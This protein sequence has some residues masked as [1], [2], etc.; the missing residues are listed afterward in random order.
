[1]NGPRRHFF[2]LHELL[3]MAALAA[4]GGVSSTMMSNIRAAV[5]A[6]VGLPGGM[7][8]TAGVHVVWLIIAVGLVR[9]PGAATVT[10][11]L[12]GT[13]ELLSGNLHGLLVILYAVLAGVGVDLVWLLLGRRH[14]PVTYMLAGGVGTASN[15]LVLPFLASLPYDEGGLIAG[16]TLLTAVAFLSGVLLAGLLGWSLLH[17]LRAAGVAGAQPP[18]PPIRPSPRT[19]AGVGVLGVALALV[20]TAIYLAVVR[21][22]VGP[23]NDTGMSPVASGDAAVPQ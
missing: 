15:V 8:F 17:T 6:V 19:W 2:T 16:M 13:V 22:E 20:G 21:A 10:G 14:R 1:M 18:E 9:K 5:H 23:V 12:K 11:L 3:I 4:L 7:Q